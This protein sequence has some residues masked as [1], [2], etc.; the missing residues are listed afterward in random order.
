MKQDKLFKSLI[1]LLAVLIVSSITGYLVYAIWSGPIATPPSNNPNPP[2]TIGG[3]P[4]AKSGKISAKAFLDYN[5]PDYYLKDDYGNMKL[6]GNLLFENALTDYNRA[7]N[8]YDPTIQYLN[9][10]DPSDPSNPKTFTGVI[11]LD[12]LPY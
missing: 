5:D 9:A 7:Y 11:P 3:S 10:F 4:Q 2:I 8:I 12:A 1:Y 6:S